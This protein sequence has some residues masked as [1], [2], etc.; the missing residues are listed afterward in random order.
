[1][2]RGAHAGIEPT[3]HR[4][5]RL[6]HLPEYPETDYRQYEQQALAGVSLSGVTDPSPRCWS[7]DQLHQPQTTYRSPTGSDRSTP[8][9]QFQPRSPAAA[10]VNAD[11]HWAT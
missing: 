7:D 9:H 2:R 11:E 10:R 6:S 1:H 4:D 5:S 3:T 8:H